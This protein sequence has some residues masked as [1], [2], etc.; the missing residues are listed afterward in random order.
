MQNNDIKRVC[1]YC[2]VSTKADK[3]DISLTSQIKYFNDL[4]NSN[5]NY[6]NMGIYAE[7]KTG[8]NQHKRSEFLEMIKECKSRNIDIIYTKTV[9]R[10]GRNSAQL[11]KTL[12]ELTKIGVRVIFEAENIDSLRDK[13]TIRTVIKSYFAEDELVKD[14]QATKFGL[15]RRYEQGKVVIPNPYPLLGYKYDKNRNLVIVPEQAKIVKEIFDRYCANEKSID[16]IRSL[17]E[18]G[19]KTSGGNTWNYSNLAYLIK[20][21]KYTGDAYLQKYYSDHGALRANRGEKAMYVVER[22]CEPI[23]THEQFELAKQRRKNHELY[24]RNPGFVPEYD[25]F[26]GIMKCGQCGANYNK[27]AN[28]H[29]TLKHGGKEKITYDCQRR[30]RYG[31]HVCNNRI[32]DRMTLEDAFVKA[33]NTMKHMIG[34]QEKQKVKNEEIEL[35]DQQIQELLNKEKIYLQMEVRGL[36]T[37][38]F[39]N[40]HQ[41][42]ISKVMKLEDRKKEIYKHNIGIR[43]QSECIDQFDKL[44]KEYEELKEFDE[45]ICKT[46][47]EQIT[48]MNRNRLIYKFRNGYTADIE[49][50]DYRLERDEIGEVKIYV[51]AKC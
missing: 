42:L 7:K 32:Q 14:S 37:E 31:V 18:R 49:I 40:Q 15:K 23:I 46:M 17:N 29:K 19:I 21:E 41:D 4:I 39:E 1:A 47:L 13:Q 34:K 25:V 48:V 20:Q 44:F 5:P 6:I 45:S 12:D 24:E 36:M 8:A 35:I 11:L 2:R 50:I 9:S 51:S 38:E 43:Q 33:F 16:I 28:G 3:Q 27:Q 10:F 26:R 30:K 22:W